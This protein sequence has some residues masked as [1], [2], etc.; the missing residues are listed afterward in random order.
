MNNDEIEMMAGIRPDAPPYGQEAKNAARRRLAAATTA[1]AGRGPLWRRPYAVALAGALAV[2]ATVAVTV[3]VRAPE[4]QIGGAE[5]VVAMPKIAPMS[6]TEVL[7]RAARAAARS[8]LE[9]RDDQFVKVESQTMYG[10][11]GGM[12]T[13]ADGNT[14]TEWRYLYRTKRAIWQSANGEKDGALRI[15][16]LEPRA[17]PGWPVPPE[18]HRDSGTEWSRLPICGKAPDHLRTDYASLKKLPADAEGMRAHLYTGERGGNSKDGAAWTAAGDMLRENYLPPAQR[19]ALFQAVG[20]IPGVDV[21]RDAED[22]AGRRGIGVGRVSAGVREDLI[23]D[24]DTYELLGERGVVVDEKTAKSPVG[25]LVASTAQLS[26][27]V[28]DSPPDAPELA[29]DTASTCPEPV[30]KTG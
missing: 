21:V 26:V 1:T 4:P 20:T 11:F 5:V 19:A 15:E 14:Q 13:D 10:A 9:P 7:G 18:A 2:A 8:D 24:P 27:T 12:G 17:Y 25:S 29:A 22:A 6:A 23:F 28:A 30:G 3:T 16:H